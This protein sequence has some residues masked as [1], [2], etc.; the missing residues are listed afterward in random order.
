MDGEVVG[1]EH[2]GDLLPKGAALAKGDLLLVVLEADAKLGVAP[3]NAAAS[4]SVLR[5]AAI[6]VDITRV[7]VAEL[8]QPQLED[9]LRSRFAGVPRHEEGGRE[10]AKD[11]CDPTHL[12]GWE[13]GGAR[14]ANN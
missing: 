9:P 2:R 14:R 8:L 7:E 13:E 12:G 3:A 1:A 10:D 11:H 5:L 4:K 6:A